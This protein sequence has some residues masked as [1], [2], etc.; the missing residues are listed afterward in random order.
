MIP[1]SQRIENV[2]AMLALGR[3]CARD[4]KAGD[5]WILDGDLGAGKT[6]WTKGFVAGIGSNQEVTSPTFSLVHEYRD[7][8]LP[9]FHF[10]FYRLKDIGELHALGWDE[11]LD[12]DAVVIVEWGKRFP[13]AFPGH[14]RTLRITSLDNGSR[15]VE[16][17]F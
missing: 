11:Y 12:Q 5:I 8:R 14:V 1:T 9:V 7:G 3:E 17:E 2:D 16:I 4:S 13:E 10:D 6:H 15:T